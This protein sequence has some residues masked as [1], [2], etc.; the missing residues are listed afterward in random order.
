MY[1]LAQNIYK[2]MGTHIPKV[3][4]PFAG[5]KPMPLNINGTGYTPPVETQNFNAPTKNNSYFGRLYQDLQGIGAGINNF[6]KSTVDTGNRAVKG[7]GRLLDPTSSATLSQ[8]FD[9]LKKGLTSVKDD[10]AP[11]LAQ[12]AINLPA[13]T[14]K[15]LSDIGTGIANSLSGGLFDNAKKNIDNFTSKITDP[16]KVNFAG[17]RTGIKQESFN[18]GQLT[19]ETAATI[20]TGAIINKTKRLTGSVKKEVIPTSKPKDYNINSPADFQEALK[21]LTF[22]RGGLYDIKSLDDV[23]FNGHSQTPLTGFYGTPHESKFRTYL[24]QDGGFK[25]GRMID[26]RSPSYIENEKYLHHPEVRDSPQRGFVTSFKLNPEYLSQIKKAERVSEPW[27]MKLP[28]MKEYL[29]KKIYGIANWDESFT[30]KRGRNG[31]IDEIVI[32]KKEVIDPK[33]FQTNLVHQLPDGRLVRTKPYIDEGKFIAP[34][35]LSPFL[36]KGQNDNTNT[37]FRNN[38]S[39]KK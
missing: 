15:G 19:G 23:K 27:S 29:E 12:G 28:R 33:S 3:T 22:K 4:N 30:A 18:I 2:P 35:L 11:G 37:L 25:T 32:F 24:E 8:R 26:P 13:N 21:E 6:V 39:K 20:G 1:K 5:A 16:F 7:W 31:P 9:W 10:F 17:N 34:A 36:L 38:F 14:V